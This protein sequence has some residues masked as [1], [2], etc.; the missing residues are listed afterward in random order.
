[1]K[2]LSKTIVRTLM[3]VG[4]FTTGTTV[5]STSG[6]GTISEAHAAV[7]YQTAYNYLVTHGYTVITLQETPERANENWVAHTVKNNVHYWTT[8]FV[9]GTSIVGHEDVVM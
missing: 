8:V 5:L 3:V 4:V 9:Q 1:M 6:A 2:N 7:S